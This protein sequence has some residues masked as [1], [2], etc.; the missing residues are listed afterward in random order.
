MKNNKLYQANVNT[1]VA[2]YGNQIDIYGKPFSFYIEEADK[3]IDNGTKFNWVTELKKRKAQEV[4]TILRLLELY[5]DTISL[6]QF[7]YLIFNE[8]PTRPNIKKGRKKPIKQ[9]NPQNK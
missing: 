9:F 5:A 6:E 7:T 3:H 4:V 1:L 2:K 8:S